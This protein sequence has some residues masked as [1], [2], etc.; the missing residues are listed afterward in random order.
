MASWRTTFSLDVVADRVLI[1]R[2]VELQEQRQASEVLRTAL[3]EHFKLQPT[4][5]ELSEQLT[6]IEGMIRELQVGTVIA[7]RE[8]AP[9][10]DHDTTTEAA[11]ALTK[12]MA[13]FKE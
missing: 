3:R 5:A 7:S 12:A 9:R 4:L 6:R 2:L 11:N 1:E 13:R 10:P 8:T